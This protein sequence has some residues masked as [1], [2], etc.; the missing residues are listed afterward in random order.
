MVPATYF[1]AKLTSFDGKQ[2]IY[3]IK[4]IS[5]L[6]HNVCWKSLTIDCLYYPLLGLL[7]A[8]VL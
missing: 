1:T 7:T 4:K 3:F 6:A 8:V 2:I 5:I